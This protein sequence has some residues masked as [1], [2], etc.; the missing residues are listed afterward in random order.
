MK[1]TKKRRSW[2]ERRRVLFF[3]IGLIVALS[4]VLVAF[5]WKST[6]EV[7]DLENSGTTVDYEKDV[8]IPIPPEQQPKPKQQ[9]K[10]AF[11]LK[12]VDSKELDKELPDLFFGGDIDDTTDYS[13]YFGGVKLTNETDLPPEPLLISSVMPSFPG[14]EAA[15]H[16]YLGENIDYPKEARAAGIE[17]TVHIEFIVEMDGTISNLKI[18]R[19]PHDL[20]QNEAVRVIR[21]MPAW[22]PGKQ[23]IR[24]VRVRMSMPIDFKLQ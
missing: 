21:N 4:V 11:K 23:G 15:M 6:L 5:E 22:N 1:T 18:Q 13:N 14:G 19:S 24:N 17:G 3:E 20:L 8:V 7:K 2:L 9:P 10:K 12:I 16:K